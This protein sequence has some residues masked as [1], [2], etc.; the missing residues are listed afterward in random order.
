MPMEPMDA[1]RDG[2]PKLVTAR[3]AMANPSGPRECSES[4]VARV[5]DGLPYDR[6]SFR[7]A[8]SRSPLGGQYDARS[9][10]PYLRSSLAS[11]AYDLPFGSRTRSLTSTDTTLVTRRDSAIDVRF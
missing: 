11:A 7:Q 5:R 4:Q 1:Y 3:I 2:E 6:S 10:S 9:Q 8:L